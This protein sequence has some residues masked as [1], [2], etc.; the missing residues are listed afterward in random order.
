MKTGLRLTG[1]ELDWTRFLCFFVV[2]AALAISV[3]VSAHGECYAQEETVTLKWPFKGQEF[4]WT[5]KFRQEDLQYYRSRQRPQTIDYS[6]YA[7]DR[8]DDQYMRELTGL[9]NKLAKQYSMTRREVINFVVTFVQHLP[10]TSDNVTTPYDEYPRFPLETLIEK[11]GDCED[12]AILA[13]TLLKEM[14]FDSLL[15]LLPRHMALAVAC[16]DCSGTNY[17]VNDRRYYYV[18]T[19]GTGWEI[20]QLPPQ[21]EGYDARLFPLV[22]QAIIDA[23]LS[24]RAMETAGR[25]HTYE[26]T[27]IARNEGSQ[28]ARNLKVW[29]AF[30]T[31]KPGTAY[32]QHATQPATVNPGEEIT[33]VV[34]LQV[35]KHVKT[36]ILVAVFGDNFIKRVIQSEW[37]QTE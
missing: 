23:D 13:A 25:L 27:V 28:P 19:T 15:V 22:S 24:F 16:D 7:S 32:S 1:R 36:R 8:M 29:H 4:T 9:F 34:T 20:G 6:I 31:E 17:E 18:E 11:G 35:P 37:M 12:T 3:L 30:A 26:I 10:Y 5:T 21:M 33:S 14:G 2:A